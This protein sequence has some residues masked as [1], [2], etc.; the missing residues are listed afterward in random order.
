MSGTLR[1]VT[2]LTWIE[3]KWLATIVENGERRCFSLNS[4]LNLQ[5]VTGVGMY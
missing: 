4:E 2:A 3:T 5:T 1:S